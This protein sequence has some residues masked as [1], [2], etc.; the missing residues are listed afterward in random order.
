MGVTDID[1]IIPASA[2]EADRAAFRSVEAALRFAFGHRR[3]QPDSLAKH[4]KREERAGSI[5][6]DAEERAAWAGA[7]RRRISTMHPTRLALV[8]LKFAPRAT[9]CACRRPCC[10]GWA[11]N[12]EWTDACAYLVDQCIAA[13]PGQISNRQLRAGVVRKW[14]GERVNLGIL[15][16]RCDVHR[17]TAGKQGKAI[18][19]WLAQLEHAAL[20]EADAC[21]I[22]APVDR[23]CTTC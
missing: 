19:K 12:E 9:P 18:F 3:G 6:E 2:D 17:N 14:A 21:L 13:V 1:A 16:E 11:R 22:G 5:F 7:I 4:Q 15:A 10:S 8:V 23:V 20:R